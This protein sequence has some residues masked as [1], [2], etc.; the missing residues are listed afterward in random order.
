MESFP[1]FFKIL[2]NKGRLR[3]GYPQA[4]RKYYLQKER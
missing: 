1:L 3:E 2:K 4:L